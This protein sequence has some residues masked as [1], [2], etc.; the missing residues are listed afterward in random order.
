M[1]G[2]LNRSRAPRQLLQTTDALWFNDNPPMILRQP[3]GFPL[4]EH[5]LVLNV[6]PAKEIAT[7]HHGMV[8][9]GGWDDHDESKNPASG[10]G[11]LTFLYPAGARDELERAGRT[12]DLHPKRKGRA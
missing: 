9:F 4:R 12:M 5:V 11:V 10:T 2:A 1:Q 7:D 3:E 6:G 8:F